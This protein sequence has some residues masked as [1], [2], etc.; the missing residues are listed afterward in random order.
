MICWPTGAYLKPVPAASPEPEAAWPSSM[1]PTTKEESWSDRLPPVPS[2]A[3]ASSVQAGGIGAH[4]G[5]GAT[6]NQHVPTVLVLPDLGNVDGLLSSRMTIDQAMRA[7]LQGEHTHT[8]DPKTREWHETSLGQL[9][10]YLAWRRVIL[11]N[12]LT[13]SE[14]RG[15]LTFLRTESLATGAFRR[16]NTISTY[17][18]SVHAFCNWLVVQGYLEQTPFAQVKVPKET[19]R[20]LRL[21]TR[22]GLREHPLLPF[23]LRDTFAIR[24]LQTDGP[25]KALRRLL[26]LAE[27]TPIKRYLD[28]A[29]S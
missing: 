19:K 3:S 24:F 25:P 9:Q 12:S 28:A 5:E 1:P 11:L 22:A 27:S 14:I 13:G 23:M 17:A 7:F 26:G 21:N 18:R 10:R 20:R 16:N 8:W 2:E 15:W 6:G 29:R 4:T